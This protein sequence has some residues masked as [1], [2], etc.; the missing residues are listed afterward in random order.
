MKKI[1]LFF[2]ILFVIIVSS[3]FTLSWFYPSD[4]TLVNNVSFNPLNKTEFTLTEVATHSSPDDCYLVIEN[5]VYN[6][7]SFIN[8][9]PGGRENITN[10]CGQEVTGLFYTIHANKVWNLLGQFYVGYLITK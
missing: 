9:H 7:S 1:T 2:L 8:T 6:V 3:I 5:N 10:N 4:I